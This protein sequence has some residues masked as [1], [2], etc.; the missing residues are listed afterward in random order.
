M[1]KYSQSI[2]HELFD[3]VQDSGCGN[4]SSPLLKSGS[5]FPTRISPFFG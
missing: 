5:F 1:L 3:L 2:V 4:L